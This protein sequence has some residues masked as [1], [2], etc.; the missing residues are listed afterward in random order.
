LELRKQLR[1]D[2]AA[3]IIGIPMQTAWKWARDGKI[4]A[5]KIGRIYFVDPERLQTLLKKGDE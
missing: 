5:V 4:P 3:N 2:E 1:L